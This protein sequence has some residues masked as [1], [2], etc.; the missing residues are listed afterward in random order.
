MNE[1]NAAK[2]TRQNMEMDNN[3]KRITTTIQESLMAKKRN[4]SQ[5]VECIFQLLNTERPQTKKQ[6]KAAAGKA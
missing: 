5:S 3:P 2:L 4:S 1:P 6:L